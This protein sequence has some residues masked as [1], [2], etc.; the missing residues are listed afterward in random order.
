M[1]N[2][3]QLIQL[4]PTV[5]ISSIQQSH[6]G[7]YTG[8]PIPTEV[9]ITVANNSHFNGNKPLTSIANTC[10]GLPPAFQLDKVLQGREDIRKILSSTSTTRLPNESPVIIPPTIDTRHSRKAELQEPSIVS[11]VVVL[12][13]ITDPETIRDAGVI[14]RRR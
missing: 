1:Y 6:L 7:S 3:L 8:E 14:P 10:D 13:D 5:E 11:Q 12:N 9:V 4:A 2:Y